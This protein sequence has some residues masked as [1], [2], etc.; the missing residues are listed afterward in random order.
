MEVACR[1]VWD[2]HGVRISYYVLGSGEEV[3]V[4]ANGLGGRLSA[5]EPLVEAIADRFR[6]ISWDYRGLFESDVPKNRAYL[7]VS[8][9]AKDLRRILDAEAVEHAVVCGWSM[10]VQVS[11]ELAA[12]A[13][14]RV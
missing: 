14:E 12:H 13:P 7:G 1:S 10:G 4:L 3:I 8:H 6:V 5:W 2:P 11:L 9:Q